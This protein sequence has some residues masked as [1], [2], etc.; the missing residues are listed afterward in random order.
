MICCSH[1]SD[2][3]NHESVFQII[4]ESTT[5]ITPTLVPVYSLEQA[6][7]LDMKYLLFVFFYL[8]PKRLAEG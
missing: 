8:I 7:F 4:N 6:S 2:Y 1:Y 5:L 3:F